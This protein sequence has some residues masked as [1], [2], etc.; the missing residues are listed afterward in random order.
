MIYPEWIIT[1][2]TSLI[3]LS[4]HIK[5]FENLLTKGWEYFFSILKKLTV[6]LVNQTINMDFSESLM[7][8]KT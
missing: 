7:F 2:G 1:L 3:P 4:F 8:F 6:N 5:L